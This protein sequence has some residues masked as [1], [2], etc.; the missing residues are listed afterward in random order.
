MN[1]SDYITVLKKSKNKLLSKYSDSIEMWGKLT[2][3]KQNLE[4]LFK[5]NIVEL[6][7]ER[8]VH[9]VTSSAKILK[10]LNGQRRTKDK[11]KVVSMITSSPKY[12]KILKSDDP[13]KIR[14]WDLEK[15]N[16]LEINIDKLGSIGL[17]FSTSDLEVL[18]EIT[19]NVLAKDKKNIKK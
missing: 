3:T 17:I 7:Y 13:L 1:I 10:Y 18:N 19:S 4:R 6:V 5:Y 8:K 15:N 2:R 9:W 16:K 11:S 12:E 14:T